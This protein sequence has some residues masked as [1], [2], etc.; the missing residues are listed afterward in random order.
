[1]K[2]SD[3]YALAALITITLASH[4]HSL[5]PKP[6]TPDVKPSVLVDELKTAFGADSERALAYADFCHAIA[7]TLESSGKPVPTVRKVSIA[8]LPK[9]HIVTPE[10]HANLSPIWD[11]HFEPWEAITDS[12]WNNDNRTAYAQAWNTLGDAC[13]KAGGR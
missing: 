11:K 10:S 3:I 1:M 5:P 6:V 7:D 4:I 2:R 13:A 9:L 12:Q 8:I